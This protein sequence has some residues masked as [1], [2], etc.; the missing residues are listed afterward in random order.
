MPIKTNICFHSHFFWM[1]F[2]LALISSWTVS[3]HSKNNNEIRSYY[4]SW[5][6]FFGRGK[7]TFKELLLR[8]TVHTVAAVCLEYVQSRCRDLLL[9]KCLGELGGGEVCLRWSA[10]KGWGTARES[11]WERWAGD[12][13]PGK[14]LGTL[15]WWNYPMY[16]QKNVQ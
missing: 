14:C 11:A 16:T 6:C 10:A 8:G 1:P 12:V 2:L 3:S 9:G 15:R 7:L 13:L 5:L 4:F